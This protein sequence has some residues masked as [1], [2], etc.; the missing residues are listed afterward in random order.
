[1]P[2]RVCKTTG[3]PLYTPSR[4]TDCPF[5]FFH[6]AVFLFT[7]GSSIIHAQADTQ[8]CHKVNGYDR[9]FDAAA[10]T[11]VG[12]GRRRW[13]WKRWVDICP[14]LGAQASPP[15]LADAPGSALFPGADRWRSSPDSCLKTGRRVCG[16]REGGG[17]A[18][19]YV[20]RFSHVFRAL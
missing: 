20:S 18:S 12:P 10:A 8:L 9:S 11:G 2:E 16:Q 6:T 3:T 19:A 1:M 17:G 7:S 5:F 4:I 13:K 14:C 15:A